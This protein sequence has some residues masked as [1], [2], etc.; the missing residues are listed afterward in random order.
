MRLIFAFIV[1][2][3]HAY[4]PHITSNGLINERIVLS[5]P[6]SSSFFLPFSLS[7]YFSL[8]LWSFPSP[9][10]SG[11]SYVF[12][13]VCHMCC[14]FLVHFSLPNHRHVTQIIHVLLV[15]LDNRRLQWSHTN[16]RTLAHNSEGI[17]LIFNNYETCTGSSPFR[18][19]ASYECS[20]CVKPNIVN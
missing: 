14:R 9:P 10:R 18:L 11:R 13:K 15:W 1:T 4:G 2:Y 19:P 3:Y 17:I 7:S 12:G 6:L 20:T 8:F 16:T 5:R